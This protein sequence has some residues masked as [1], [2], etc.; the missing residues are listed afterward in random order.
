MGEGGGLRVT[1]H[2]TNGFPY[3]EKV[4]K[5][6][7]MSEPKHFKSKKQN[8]WTKPF[9]CRFSGLGKPLVNFIF[10][11]ELYFT[12]GWPPFYFSVSNI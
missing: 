5:K 4:R 8:E 6:K 3:L 2:F 10:T 1:T 9:P 7:Q 11:T 12:N